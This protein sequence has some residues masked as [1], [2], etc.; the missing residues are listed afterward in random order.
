MLVL[1]KKGNLDDSITLLK[2][3]INVLRKN[4]TFFFNILTGMSV[5]CVYF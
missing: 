1:M 2:K 3:S 5:S 4:S